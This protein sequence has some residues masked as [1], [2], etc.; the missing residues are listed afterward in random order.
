MNEGLGTFLG[1]EGWPCSENQYEMNFER[2][3][4]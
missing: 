2:P 1:R 3:N 4:S